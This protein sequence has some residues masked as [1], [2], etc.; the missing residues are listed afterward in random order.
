MPFRLLDTFQMLI[1]LLL[2]LIGAAFLFHLLVFW[3]RGWNANFV[4]QIVPNALSAW[5]KLI[6]EADSILT[7][8]GLLLFLRNLFVHGIHLAET[9]R[10]YRPIRIHLLNKWMKNNLFIRKRRKWNFTIIPGLHRNIVFRPVETS[11]DDDESLTWEM[12]NDF[13][14]SNFVI[15]LELGYVYQKGFFDLIFVNKY[16]SSTLFGSRWCIMT[17]FVIVC[18]HTLVMA[19]YI[20]KFLLYLEF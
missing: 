8:V 1:W 3:L 18:A 13:A 9:R 14:Q 2:L 15:L 4:L 6:A 12:K 5:I 16:K 17:E 11:V 20:Y 7:V 10:Q 19:F